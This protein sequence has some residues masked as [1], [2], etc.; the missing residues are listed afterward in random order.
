MTKDK[1]MT[2]DERRTYLRIVQDRYRQ[3]GRKEKGRM[4]DEM[5]AITKLHRKSL[6]RLLKGD[7]ER[8]P[9]RRQGG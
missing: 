2:I 6:I 4:L 3:A 8:H 5:E 1:K 7:L 9:R